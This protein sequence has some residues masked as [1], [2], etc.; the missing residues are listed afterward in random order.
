MMIK[1]EV[2]FCFL[3]LVCSSTSQ[4]LMKGAAISLQR[5]RQMY[6]IGLAAILQF[7]SVALVFSAL[8]VLSLAQVA[9][10]AA[11]AYLLV[12]LGGHH[13][14]RESLCPSFWVGSLFIAVGIVMTQL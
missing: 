1:A 6:Y 7:T 8:R 10:F 12:P 5:K 9:P 3:S 14:F 2:A 4:L 11:G 13:I